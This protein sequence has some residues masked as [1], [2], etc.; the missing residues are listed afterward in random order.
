MVEREVMVMGVHSRR[1]MDRNRN[2]NEELKNQE[3]MLIRR[4]SQWDGIRRK[5]ESMERPLERIMKELMI[6]EVK[7]SRIRLNGYVKN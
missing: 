2:C 6:C 4:K 7:N 5:G 3:V 1:S